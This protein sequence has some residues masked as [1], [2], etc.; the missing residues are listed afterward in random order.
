MTQCL[1]HSLA[2][3]FADDTRILRKISSNADAVLLQ[4]DLLNN[5]SHWSKQN[6][7][8]LNENKFQFVSHKFKQS[9]LDILP[10]SDEHL[11]YVT[12]QGQI[13]EP[14]NDVIDLGVNISANLQWKNQIGEMV[15]KSRQSLAWVLSIIYDRSKN[16]MMLLYKSFVRSKLE[17]CCPLWHTNKL[18]DIQLAESVQRSF[19]ARISGMEQLN[20]WERLERLKIQSLQRRRERFCIF[21][22]WKVIYGNY[23]NDL[24]FQ[25]RLSDRRGLIVL[26]SPVRNI[27]SRVQTL[28]D[29]S[30][31][32]MG[33]QLWNR[34]PK[35]I[36]LISTFSTFKIKVD[37]FLSSIPDKPP[38]QGYPYTNNNSLLAIT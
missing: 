25:Y 12:Q 21:Y 17:Y 33:P 10:F 31:A 23:T 5:I 9:P 13:L 16:A 6:N 7:M 15:N 11:F 29:N 32:V 19:T 26:V 8:D 24:N 20:Y 27:N 2:G 22:M 34:L 18:C 38:I 30:F 35:D 14:L 4:E 1:K 3:I 28:Y 36:S 37:K